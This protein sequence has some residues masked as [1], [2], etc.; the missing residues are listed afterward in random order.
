MAVSDTLITD[1]D[2]GAGNFTVTVDFSEAM[3]TTVDPT[4]AFD[5]AVGGT[6]TFNS[7]GWTGNDTY[8]ASYDVA[9][10]NVD[11]D[12][13]QIDVTGAKDAAG[14]AQQD[15]T[16]ENEF[17]ID[18]LNPTVTNVVANDALITDADTPGD[19]TFV[20]TIDFS[21]PMDTGVAPTVTF[22][23]AVASTLTLD[24][25]S[26]WDD[27]DTY[28]AKYDVADGNVDVDNVQID[29]TG[30]KDAAGNAQ[31]DYTPEN[32]FGIDTKNPT[33]TVVV[34]PTT[35][36]QDARL[37]TVTV[38]Y[39][40]PMDPTT[41][42]AITVT[43]THWG[44]QTPVGTTGWSAGNTV[45]TATF[46]HD[47]T[48]ESIPAAVASIAPGSGA[49]DIAGNAENA[50]ISPSFIVDLV[51]PVITLRVP[52]DEA[53]YG[54]NET[55]SADWTAVDAFPGLATASAADDVN[56]GMASGEPFYT[57]SVGLHDFTVTARDRAGN[58]STI[59]VTYR[60]VYT[61]LPGGAAGGGGAAG[62]QQ[63]GFLDK[64]IA[65]GGG[66][67]GEANLEAIYTVGDIIHASFSLTDST[68]EPITDAVVSCTVVKVQLDSDGET[69]KVVKLLKFL[70]NDDAKL[71]MLDIPTKGW[72]AGIYDLWLGFD[73]GTTVRLRI[74][75]QKGGES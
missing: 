40:E 59:T 62:K 48:Q 26:G 36:Y 41:A 57:G 35:I 28:L 42:P 58:T 31:Q 34:T 20:V 65:G 13:V 23:P 47:G 12:N 25:S 66:T 73:D 55:V 64:S 2:V 45:Y 37:L 67:V 27:N 49:T 70:Y 32:E 16:P 15:Y 5:P 46:L 43:G 17:G 50:G 39:D 29:V 6:L 14:N 1:A 3:D 38:T 7:G 60:V 72:L 52:E 24:P 11:V 21:E 61:V 10:A 53:E 75:L 56:T 68:G 54:L 9:D 71:Y 51:P 44:P 30:A 22:T 63:P 33:P 18:T 19:A 69:Y 4:I 74:E 8:Q